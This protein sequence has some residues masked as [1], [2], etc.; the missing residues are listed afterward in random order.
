[1]DATLRSP[2]ALPPP[3]PRPAARRPRELVLVFSTASW[4]GVRRRGYHTG[5]RLAEAV[6]ADPE[7]DRVLVVNPYRSAPRRAVRWALGDHGEPFPADPSRTLLQPFRLRG[8]D[9]TTVRGLERAY[10]AYGRRIG[11]AADEAGFSRP[12]VLC[13]NPLAAGFA[14]FSWADGVTF[15]AEDDLAADGALGP[16]SAAISE[17]YR[18]IAAAGAAVGAVSEVIVDR[19]APRG[20]SAVVPNGVEPAEWSNLPAP[21]AWLTRL[22]GP[23]VLYLGIVNDRLDL[24]AIRDVAERRPRGSVVFVGGMPDPGYVAPLRELPNVHFRP[25][26]QRADVPGIVAGA[27][28]CVVPHR[29]TPLTLAMSPLKLY[30]YLAAGRPVVATEMAPMRGIDPRVELVAP[31]DDFAAGVGRAL[32]LPPVPEAERRGFIAAHSWERRLEEILA[33]TATD[34]GTPR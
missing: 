28:V 18:R 17:A 31:G 29:V 5:D 9:P 30:E 11:R 8:R 19:I 3:S 4:D 25:H 24:D 21:P 34:G 1:M 23:R 26:V 12:R 7:I 13:L 32:A 16:W 6:L 22:P 10:R 2:P 20:P 33:L 27:D 14:D 15:F